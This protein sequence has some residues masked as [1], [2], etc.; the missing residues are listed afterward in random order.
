MTISKIIRTFA[1]YSGYCSVLMGAINVSVQPTTA[2]LSAGQSQQ[3]TDSLTGAK[4]G[5]KATGVTW[6][7][8]VGTITTSGFYTAPNT[9]TQQTVTVKAS[10]IQDPTATAS[11]TV[12]VLAAQV[13][14]GA[15]TPTAANM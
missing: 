9:S 8:S 11:S 7:A 3:F 1:L 14:S 4:Q 2:T 5:S 12:T 13:V 6:S 10:S 15:V